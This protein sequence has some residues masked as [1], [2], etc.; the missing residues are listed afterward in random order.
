[1]LLVRLHDDQ[2]ANTEHVV[3]AKANRTPFDLEAHGTAVVI[4]LGDVAEDLRVDFGADGFGE[5]LGEFGVGDLAGKRGF[6]AEGS[7]FVEFW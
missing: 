1:M 4:E 7:L 6:H 2:A 3:A 5:V